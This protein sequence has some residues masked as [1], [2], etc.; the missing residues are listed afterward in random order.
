MLNPLTRIVAQCKTL[1]AQC[2]VAENN[3]SAAAASI[4]DSGLAPLL[5]PAFIGSPTAPTP[6]ANSGSALLATTEYLDRMLAAANGIATLG[7]TGV[8]PIAQLPFA[9]VQ[10]AGTWN[11]TTNT[12]TLVSGSG[13]VSHF[14]IVSVAGS[15]NLN[16]ITTWAVGD[17][18]LFDGA[19]WNRVTYTAPPLSNIPLSALAGQANNTIVA[20]TAGG[21]AFPTAVAIS[22]ITSLL[23]TMVG[24]SGAGGTKGLVP[25][26]PVGSAAALKVLY[27]DG[28]WDVVPLPDLSIYALLNG[29][30]F[31]GTP[32]TATVARNTNSTAIDTAG[33]VIAQ[34]ASATEMLPVVNGTA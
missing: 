19:T 4:G 11:A 22:S 32:T 3:A 25:A 27:A 17:W 20:Q 18:A 9:G 21:T 1:L 29:P 28:T 5:S 23:S 16:G 6:P 12:P 15:T 10:Y 34:L 33:F 30:A 14:Y 26:P 7:P 31:L 13:V 2:V 8:I 24:D